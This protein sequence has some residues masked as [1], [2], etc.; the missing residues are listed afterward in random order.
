MSLYTTGELAKKCNVSVRTIQYYDERGILVP[1]DLTEG[2][3]RLFSEEDVATLETICFLRDLDI[4]I[5]DIAQILESD[6]SKKVIELLLDEQ[7][8]NIQADI[9]RKTEQLEKIKGIRNTLASFKDGSQKTI[10]DISTIM[11]EKEK[12]RKVYKKMLVIAV[13]LEA[14]EI[15]TFVIGILRGIWIPFFMALAVLII[16]TVFLVDYWYKQT[17]YIC[18]E[19]HAR[20]QPKKTEVVLG[21]HT[22][23][24]RK[25]TCPDCKRK[26]WCLE[27]HRREVGV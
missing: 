22:P 16:C 8:K 26:I 14:A 4:S 27:V 21:N 12:L 11:E 25:L 15:V 17:E 2:G 13:P 7:D 6:E 20:F 19:C 5:K 9:R 24:M 18:P 3:R 10:H 23:K 1:T